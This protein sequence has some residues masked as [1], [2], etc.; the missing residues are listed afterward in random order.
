MT[1]LLD[2][3]IGPVQRVVAQSRRT[4]DL[5]S[6]S[7]LLAYLSAHA[8][9]AALASGAELR[10]PN[11]DKDPLYAW[12]CGQRNGPPP[13]IGSVP[14]HFT[15]AVTDPPRAVAERCIEAFN[16]AWLT[17]CDAVWSEF[18]A[19]V[20]H[21]GH[22]SKAVWDRQVSGFWEIQWTAGPDDTLAAAQRRNRRKQWQAHL[23]AGELGGKCS[24]MYDYQELSGYIPVTKGEERDAF[25][26]AVRHWVN[27]TDAEAPAQDDAQTRRDKSTWGDI[28]QDERLCAVAAV[29]RL[30][31]LIAKKA[32]GWP[33]EPSRWLSTVDIAAQP[34]LNRV[35]AIAPREGEAY[36]QA[37]L[38]LAPGARRHLRARLAVD[39]AESRP[40]WERVD[41]NCFHRDSVSDE[42]MV[43]FAT[44]AASD[45]EQKRQ[46]EA[47]TRQ[48]HEL[49]E[50][51]AP[52]GE[53]LGAPPNA[54]AL[55]LAD[56]DRL[57][58]LAKVMPARDIGAALNRFTRKVPEIAATF[59]ALPIYAG[60][61]D[62]LVLLPV[63][64]ALGCAAA[65]ADSYRAAF[66][67]TNP[68]A[69]AKA[70]PTLSA[71][72]VFA[73]IR[74]PLTMVLDEAHWL[75]DDIAK[76]ANGR[77]SI[78]VSLF[79]RGGRRAL[80]VSTWQRATASA[81]AGIE[82]LAGCL[83]GDTADL[84]TNRPGELSTSL[85]FRLRET[86]SLLGDG[87]S[88]TPGQWIDLPAGT[89]LRGF[90]HAEIV[91]GL[92]CRG[93]ADHAGAAP[94]TDLI[95]AHLGPAR[96]GQTT[97]IV[98]TTIGMDGLLV[99]RFLAYPEFQEDVG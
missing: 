37:L 4:R 91:R 44:T 22:G 19:P 38:G 99:A 79:K 98:P 74:L 39:R 9:R 20:A 73:H 49:T 64:Q 7:Y 88:W 54:Y 42:G 68:D 33:L 69:A 29:K 40:I 1:Q 31:P 23:A 82:Q 83:R 5:W 15:V 13:A 62:V 63:P 53:K 25:W 34:W 30:F 11:L 36:C 18:F 27:Q 81:V 89:D 87:P 72:V 50:T 90:L 43:P 16:N 45:A 70:Q 65:L 24:M 57:G 67:E 2:F 85:L 47:L 80:W 41:A 21:Q 3:S 26:T 8:L 14:N 12:V 93:E 77:N 10:K 58:D 86:L 92:A 96:A 32:I 78:A 51:R 52:N 95:L 75:L 84:A 94:L 71:A 76:K 35:A 97:P 55:I 59:G 28:R 56:G 61:D 6:S 48:L 60:G 17:I 66:D 46:R